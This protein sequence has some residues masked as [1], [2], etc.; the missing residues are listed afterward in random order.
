MT[1]VDFKK[2]TQNLRGEVIIIHITNKLQTPLNVERILHVISEE[3]KAYL[4]TMLIFSSKFII[5]NY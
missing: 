1:N 2:L 5:N 4:R 3:H